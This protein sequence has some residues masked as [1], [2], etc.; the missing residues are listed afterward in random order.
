[1]LL[2]FSAS[3]ARY[4][5]YNKL[6]PPRAKIINISPNPSPRGT[7]VSFSGEGDGGTIIAHMWRSNR[8]GILSTASAFST[9]SLSAGQHTI[10]YKVINNRYVW[11]AEDS[12]ELQ[13]TYSPP[14]AV[15]LEI[16]PD[17]AN[18]GEM[19]SF[20]GQ[21]NDFDG[22]ITDHEWRSNIGGFLSNSAAFSTASLSAG[23]HTIMY[24][25]RDNSNIWSPYVSQVL[26]IN[27]PQPPVAFIDAIS[28]SPAIVG[29][30]VSF[31]GH[32]EDP[33]GTITGYE[34]RSDLDGLLSADP[35][36]S[37]AS[38][39][40]GL[41]S[42]RFK[43]KDDDDQWSTEISKVL[44]IDV[45]QPPVAKLR[46]EFSTDIV[47]GKTV[48]N[49]IVDQS[50]DPDGMPDIDT[51]ELDVDF[52]GLWNY[53]R[54]VSD[55][56]QHPYDNSL[57]GWLPAT[58]RVT[59]KHGA[60]S[61]ATVSVLLTPFDFGEDNHRFDNTTITKIV[62]ANL[63]A[64]NLARLAII[65]KYPL[66]RFSPAV[67]AW[68]VK[69]IAFAETVGKGLCAGMASTAVEYFPEGR[70]D[71]F[72]WIPTDEQV[73]RL[74][75]DHHV[76]YNLGVIPFGPKSVGDDAAIRGELA[77]LKMK[78]L[79]GSPVALSVNGE[80]CG[81]SFGHSVVAYGAIENSHD[82]Y[83]IAIYD[84]N[85]TGTSISEPILLSCQ[86]VDA[87]HVWVFSFKGT[88]WTND[89]TILKAGIH[90]RASL[91][92]LQ[93]LW[94][95]FMD[96]LRSPLNGARHRVLVACPVEVI[97]AD[98]MGHA[99]G[100][101]NGD[102]LSQIPGTTWE[103]DFG[104]WSFDIPNTGTYSLHL[105]GL[106]EDSADVSIF[107]SNSDG[108]IDLSSFR[109]PVAVNSEHVVQFGQ[110]IRDMFCSIDLD[111]DGQFESEALATDW[112][113]SV[114]PTDI[115]D[116]G[117][118]SGYVLSE[119]SPLH[120]V[121]VDLT[122]DQG[123][124]INS[125]TT[126]ENGYYD[127]GTLSNG[128]YVVTLM[129]P[130]G[131]QIVSETREVEIMGFQHH[132]NFELDKIEIVASM[133]SRAY[134]AHQLHKALQK[135]PQDYTLAN[136]ATFAGLIN[137]HFNQNQVNP[138]DF[139]TVPQPASQQDSLMELK[140]LLHMCQGEEEPFLKRFAKAQLMALMLNVVSGKISQTQVISADGRT[141]SQAITYCD[142]LVNEE[143]DCPDGVPGH[144]SPHCRYILADFILTF[145]NLGLTIPNDMIPA[146][147]VQIAYRIHNQENLPVGFALHQNYPNPFN[148]ECE[149]AYDL[150]KDCHVTLSIYNVLGQKVKVLVD[151]N[152]NAGN[153]SV[154]WGGKDEQ[155]QEVTSGIYFYRIQAGDFVQSKKMVLLR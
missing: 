142:M 85:V 83:S 21:G 118:L 113:W 11:S 96:R 99:N 65:E 39:S 47:A 43:V 78:L 140:K 131:Y 150:P 44:Q 63:D 116:N 151:Q 128:S 4:N 41:H 148:P 102:S 71:V 6:P 29:E 17:Q 115:T 5:G 90:E 12:R 69:D 100:M 56:I 22:V 1:M 2:L 15:I 57:S 3:T 18:E 26:E 67:L 119:G 133:Q 64:N 61:T 51:Y 80:E 27:Q 147:I 117:T 50:D 73:Q 9:S 154:K 129:T 66:L 87:F 19:V 124:L 14:S 23:R 95:M 88:T 125:A 75:L 84:N 59:D 49:F 121:A 52:D 108:T 144:G 32:G 132:A 38:L 127:F 28:P 62:K 135:R 105:R 20:I 106:G 91:P 35:A 109:V 111:G 112:S 54:H 101:L 98:E 145:A 55:I 93:Q 74:I 37:T 120:G 42:I 137:V 126:D 107:V 130:L 134:W 138:V 53:T 114:D 86:W 31:T 152:E 33:D 60:Q 123:D 81:K 153:K 77:E 149:I 13:I 92:S 146:D 143:I 46:G 94:D 48:V 25:V 79:A 139:Y 82:E 76:L 141:V 104:I 30:T 136:F 68:L 110:G 89:V 155:G 72:S 34:W 24:R 8:D 58:L 122:N 103:N 40:A 36:F 70:G 97:V 7:V 10:Y 16:R 45:N